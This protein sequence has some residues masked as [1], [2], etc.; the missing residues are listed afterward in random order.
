MQEDVGTVELCVIYGGAEN[1]PQ[2]ID[3]TFGQNDY[4]K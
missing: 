2:I 1:A 4:G 3:A